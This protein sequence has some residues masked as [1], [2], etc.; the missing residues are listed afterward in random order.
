MQFARPGDFTIDSAKPRKRCLIRIIAACSVAF[1]LAGCSRHDATDDEVAEEASADA[2]AEDGSAG[3]SAAVPP[4]PPDAWRPDKE[5]ESLPSS[6]IYYTLTDYAWYAHGEPLLH[7]GRPHV[8]VGLPIAASV[9]EMEKVGEYEGV[10]Y[11]T[12]RN[13]PDP[14]LYVP[15]FEG[16][17]L[18]FRLSTIG[19]AKVAESAAQ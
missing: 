5:R 14:V 1:P 13:D 16:Y 12:R 10:D 18:T 19:A 7:E 11:Y 15:V 4:A 3:S 6:R 8:P 17:W 2:S 9:E